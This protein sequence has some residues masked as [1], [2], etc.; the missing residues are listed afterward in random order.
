L[1]FGLDEA[2]FLAALPLVEAA[3]LV[4]VA[5][6]FLVLVLV[7]AEAAAALADMA[8]TGW[9]AERVRAERKAE[10]LNMVIVVAGVSS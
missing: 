4:G 3:A 5:D 8:R 1:A 2:S 9:A 6:S 7:V 10:R